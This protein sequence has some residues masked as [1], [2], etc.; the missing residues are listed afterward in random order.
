VR[1]VQLFDTFPASALYIAYYFRLRSSFQGMKAQ[2]G[3]TWLMEKV[4]TLLNRG[5]SG[6][7]VLHKSCFNHAFISGI[8]I[9][10]FSSRTWAKQSIATIYKKISKFVMK[11]EKKEIL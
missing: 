7:L 2:F 8:N 3:M 6:M 9:C 10:T 11:F 1:V 4:Y 5:W